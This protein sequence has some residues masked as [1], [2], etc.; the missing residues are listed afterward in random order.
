MDI[1]KRILNERYGGWFP[2]IRIPIGETELLNNEV[3]LFVKRSE[4]REKSIKRAL[5]KGRTNRTKM[6][7]GRRKG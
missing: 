2:R 6:K 3:D 4:E 5:E 1:L 7:K